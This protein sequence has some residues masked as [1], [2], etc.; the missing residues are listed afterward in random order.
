MARVSTASRRVT[1]VLGLFL[2]ALALQTPPLQ[3]QEPT[4]SARSDSAANAVKRAPRV[5]FVAGPENLRDTHAP[6][7]VYTDSDYTLKA[8]WAVHPGETV[9]VT[10]CNVKGCAF[11]LGPTEVDTFYLLRSAL[12]EPNVAMAQRRSRLEAAARAQA[13][14]QAARDSARAKTLVERSRLPLGK[15]RTMVTR[16]ELDSTEV[17]TS[18][19]LDAENKIDSAFTPALVLR[20]RAGRESEAYV[21]IGVFAQSGGYGVPVRWRLDEGSVQSDNW[22]ESTDYQALFA[23]TPIAFAQQLTKGRMLRFEFTRYHSSAKVVRFDLTGLPRR[24]AVVAQAC[25]WEY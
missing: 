19:Q 2:V 5:M 14:M 3:S 16:S 23:S 4:Q 12:V 1:P 24:L 15:W 6:V 22:S 11:V 8:P 10:T 25:H 13:T 9:W 18:I 21:V 20:C 7:P 17:T